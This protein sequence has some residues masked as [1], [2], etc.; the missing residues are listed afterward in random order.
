MVEH[1]KLRQNIRIFCLTQESWTTSG[2]WTTSCRDQLAATWWLCFGKD[3]VYKLNPIQVILSVRKINFWIIRR[4]KITSL[5]IIFRALKSNNASFLRHAL[6]SV[7]EW[8][9]H[10]LSD[11]SP[12]SS[13]LLTSYKHGFGEKYDHFNFFFFLNFSLQWQLSRS[14]SSSDPTR[15]SSKSVISFSSAAVSYNYYLPLL[16]KLGVF[17]NQGGFICFI[18][19]Q[20]VLH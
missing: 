17:R 20:T 18:S 15:I 11:I 3:E 5:A 1:E 4:T 8:V 10:N 2:L 16:L 6:I 7:V 9:C 12:A 19:R 14:H 13:P